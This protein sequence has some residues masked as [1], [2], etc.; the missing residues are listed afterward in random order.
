MGMELLKAYRALSRHLSSDLVNEVLATS[1]ACLWEFWPNEIGPSWKCGKVTG[2]KTV[3][4]WLEDIQSESNLRQYRLLSW[5]LERTAGDYCNLILLWTY[6]DAHE[7]DYITVFI[8]I[9][10]EDEPQI[11]AWLE[12]LGL[13][14]WTLNPPALS[15]PIRPLANEP[16]ETTNPVKDIDGDG[17]VDANDADLFTHNEPVQSSQLNTI[18][19]EEHTSTN[20]GSTSGVISSP[21]VRLLCFSCIVVLIG[22]TIGTLFGRWTAP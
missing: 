13:T 4:T 7:R 11:F 19:P 17:S 10:T 5:Q 21:Q 22:I 9:K 2:S 8:F 6:H 15:S 18:V 1:R 20:V 12:N 14:H 16:E 3:E